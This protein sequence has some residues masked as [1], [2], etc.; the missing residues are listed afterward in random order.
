MRCAEAVDG[1]GSVPKDC[2][3]VGGCN[4]QSKGLWTCCE[5]E[6]FVA[7]RGDSAVDVVELEQGSSD[8]DN[9]EKPIRQIPVS[10][11]E[12]T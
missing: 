2:S 10:Q 5:L 6:C 3:I 11:H 8:G 1:A 7:R 9:N 12:T 4:G